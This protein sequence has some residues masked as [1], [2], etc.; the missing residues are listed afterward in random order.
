MA[1]SDQL[2]EDD[3]FEDPDF[4]QDLIDATEKEEMK[5][6]RELLIQDL[7]KS[8]PK[9]AH[10]SSYF[11]SLTGPKKQFDSSV[12]V[13][14]YHATSKVKFDEPPVGFINV[15]IHT[16][17]KRLGGALSPFILRN[18]TH[19]ILENLWQFSKVYPKVNARRDPKSRFEPWKI[20]WEHPFQ[21]HLNEQTGVIHPDYWNWRKKGF[22]CQEPIRYPNGYNDRHDCKFALWPAEDQSSR[23]ERFVLAPNGTWYEKLN[24]IEARKKIYC[25]LYIDSCREHPEFLKLKAMIDSGKKL[26]IVEVDGPNMS[27]YRQ[28][29]IKSSIVGNSLIITETVIKYL[30]ND[31]AHPF[32]HGYVIAALLL[33]GEEWLK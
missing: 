14:K 1:A 10:I 9:T 30:I 25:A 24:Y 7:S 19:C 26:N 11:P 28:S 22:M 32:G 23:G 2:P 16:S 20:I 31:P 4:L 13:A 27:W 33:G 5:Y 12:C 6:E 18:R 3:G 8:T 21:V 15:I 17:S 29:P